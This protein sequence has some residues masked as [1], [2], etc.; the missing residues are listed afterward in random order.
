MDKGN[1][2]ELERYVG[3]KIG[4]W[5]PL[6]PVV[7]SLSAILSAKIGERANVRILTEGVREF[8][9]ANSEGDYTEEVGV[10]GITHVRGFA[11]KIELFVDY[12]LSSMDFAEGV[13]GIHYYDVVNR[14]HEQGKV[15]HELIPSF[16]HILRP[17]RNHYEFVVNFNSAEVDFDMK[18]ITMTDINNF[19]FDEYDVYIGVSS[20]PMEDGCIEFIATA[21][22]CIGN[23]LLGMVD[24]LDVRKGD[25]SIVAYTAIPFNSPI[26]A[27]SFVASVLLGAILKKAYE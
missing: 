14:L 7:F 20:L 3:L 10:D 21:C 15:E 9:V 5:L 12:P 1:S 26:G 23:E 24:G 27:F 2:L 17:E 11:V 19:L 4:S 18:G 22:G 8:L 25:N 16:Y 13:T 6:E